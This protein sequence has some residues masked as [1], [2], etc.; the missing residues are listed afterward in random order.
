MSNILYLS[1][2]VTGVELSC[3]FFNVKKVSKSTL[4]LSD[5]GNDNQIL[6][7]SAGYQRSKAKL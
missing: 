4:F 3:P 1:P 6:P 7:S 5:E 2:L